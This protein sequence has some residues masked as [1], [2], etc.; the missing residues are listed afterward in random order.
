MISIRLNFPLSFH[1]AEIPAGTVIAVPADIAHSFL[2]REVAVMAEPERAVVQPEETREAY[3]PPAK[4]NRRK[5]R[6]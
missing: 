6:D 3:G 4:R 1:H 2:V 5:K